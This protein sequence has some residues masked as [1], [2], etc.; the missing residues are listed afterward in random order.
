[1]NDIKYRFYNRSMRFELTGLT[2]ANIGYTFNISNM[3]DPQ[4]VVSFVHELFHAMSYHYGLFKNHPGNQSQKIAR[5]EMYAEEF[6][7]YCGLGV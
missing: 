7:L 1:M 5:D 3:N 2:R 6:T 4:F